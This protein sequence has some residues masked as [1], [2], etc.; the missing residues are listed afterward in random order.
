MKKK[1]PHPIPAPTRE[2]W[3]DN[4]V[5][6]LREGVFKR[7]HYKVPKKIYVSTSFAYGKKNAVGQYWPGKTSD[8][9]KG[10]ITICPRQDAYDAIDTLVHELCHA[11]TPGKGHGPDFRRCA[12]AVGLVGPMRTAGAGIHLEKEL[13]E[14]LK[15]TLGAYPHSKLNI[16]MK[17]VKPQTTRMIKMQCA[18]CGYIARTTMKNIDESGPLI[19]PCN[20]ER[21]YVDN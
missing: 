10:H 18:E 13:R 20:K 3:L 4:A 8:D 12:I 9:K 16:N 1:M 7:S 21:M 6:V 2:A 14:I 11:C 19:C 5:H 15:N 17:P